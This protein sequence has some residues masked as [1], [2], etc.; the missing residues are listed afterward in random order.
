[1]TPTRGSLAK[2]D[3]GRS[4]CERR[5]APEE[6]AAKA[7][8]LLNKGVGDEG[9]YRR[10]LEKYGPARERVSGAADHAPVVDAIV[11]TCR[12]AQHREGETS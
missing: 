1:M 4:L 12:G 10:V 11:G 7:N 9:A 5:A 8:T 6:A 3:L 2:L